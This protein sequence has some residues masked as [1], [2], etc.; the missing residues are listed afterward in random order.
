M[1]LQ[2]KKNCGVNMA[3]GELRNFFI[4]MI[5]TFIT[6]S[7]LKMAYTDYWRW[8]NYTFFYCAKLNAGT[9]PSF[10]C[11]RLLLPCT[12]ANCRLILPKV[13][14]IPSSKHRRPTTHTHRRSHFQRFPNTCPPKDSL[15]KKSHFLFFLFLADTVVNIITMQLFI[16]STSGN[17]GDFYLFDW[18]FSPSLAY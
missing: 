5:I 11:P 17:E 7:K 1:A 8:N 14:W 4:L 15:K 10:N 3:R 12:S 18:F 2:M 9:T 16:T 6:V 13:T